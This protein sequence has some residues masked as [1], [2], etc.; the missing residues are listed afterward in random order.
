VQ[1]PAGPRPPRTTPHP[2]PGTT[3]AAVVRFLAPGRRPRL[4][5][6]SLRRSQPGSAD[7]E[8]SDFD[9]HRERRCPRRPPRSQ[10]LLECE[11]FVRPCCPLLA[12]FH[13]SLEFDHRR[14]AGGR[15]RHGDRCPRGRA[16][17]TSL[18]GL[19]KLDT[20]TMPPPVGV[21]L[22]FRRDARKTSRVRVVVREIDAKRSFWRRTGAFWY[23]T[24]SLALHREVADRRA[25][26]R[27]VQDGECSHHGGRRQD[28]EPRAPSV[29]QASPP[30]TRPARNL[31][32]RARPAR[33][34]GRLGGRFSIF[35]S[36]GPGG[37]NSARTAVALLR[38]GP[39]SSAE[40]GASCAWE[41]AIGIE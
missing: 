14:G 27:R 29:V 30:P 18:T 17:A 13:L 4:S 7:G 5:Y 28:L 11:G 22:A 25:A 33:R 24:L 34:S 15:V 36:G 39:S 38:P 41:S 40:R 26:R 23:P 31:E 10:L 32:P 35:G 1:R 9:W 12:R 19:V 16:K 6:S 8:P 21:F 2:R 3:T 20:E 37:R